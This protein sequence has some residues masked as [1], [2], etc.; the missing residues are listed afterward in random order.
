MTFR[1]SLPG[2]L[3]PW[4]H[5]SN[6]TYKSKPL[7]SAR[8]SRS[9]MSFLRWLSGASVLLSSLLATHGQHV[10]SRASTA[11]APRV[12]IL[13]MF[14]DE[15]G[16]WY[17]IPEFNVLAKNI[18][19][20]G[21]SPLFPQ[22][23]CT[24]NHDICQLTTGEGES[25]A[26]VSLTAL[27]YSPLVNLTTTYIL[28]AGIAGI[29]PK[30]ATVGSVTFARYAVQV[31]LQYEIDPREVPPGWSTGY[32]P[33][34]STAPGQ[35]PGVFYGTE[36]YELND[37]LRQRAFNVAKTAKLNDSMDALPLR[38]QYAQN[39]DFVSGG[40]SPPKVAL[41]D[42]ATS[43]TYWDGTLLAEA[44]ENTVK[45]FTN[46]S[47]LYC[48][49]QQEDNATLQ[50]LLRGA[51][52]KRVDFSRIIIMRTA[53]DFDRQGPNQ[54]AVDSLLGPEPGY[55]PSILNIKIAGIKVVDMILNGWKDEFECG[56]TAKNYVGDVFDSLGGKLKPDF[57]PKPSSK[58]LRR[59]LRRNV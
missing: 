36:I 3:W 20:P 48:S 1:R 46:G 11:I 18:T 32:F 13:S 26:A 23:H 9:S 33:Q 19:I 4:N 27:T 51:L 53:S 25:N 12:L 47:G 38:Q 28:I 44:F 57:I 21:L 37:A 45:V 31:G 35:F 17:D 42:T 14:D 58:K 15:G 10:S 16:A 7:S 55:E 34:D 29:N 54:T 30:I 59:Q 52:T 43:D 41:C 40:G 56:I 39:P 49:T 2:S 50:A 22:L 24:T 5:V 6:R 8:C